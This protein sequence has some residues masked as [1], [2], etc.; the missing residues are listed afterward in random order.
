MGI[1]RYY[2]PRVLIAVII[3]S[4]CTYHN[5]HDY[6]IIKNQCS[7]A[8]INNKF[9]EEH[10]DKLYMKQNV[11]I[12]NNQHVILDCGIVRNRETSPCSFGIDIGSKFYCYRDSDGNYQHDRHPIERTIINYLII[13]LTIFYVADLYDSKY[14]TNMDC[15]FYQDYQDHKYFIF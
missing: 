10:P 5:Y 12:D 9:F 14:Y 4:F 15:Y 7:I 3:G 11:T 2:F 8:N 1:S 6:E 13:F